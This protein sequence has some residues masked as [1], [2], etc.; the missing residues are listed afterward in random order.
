MNVHLIDA[1][2][3]PA[4][5]DRTYGTKE[6]VRVRIFG[7]STGQAVR[8]SDAIE[9]RVNLDRSLSRRYP[10]PHSPLAVSTQSTERALVASQVLATILALEILHA[11]VRDTNAERFHLVARL[12]LSNG[13]ASYCGEAIG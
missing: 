9:E 11:E 1:A 8:V 7:A 6:A 4:L 12:Q 10:R 5:F 3:L 13:R 2:I